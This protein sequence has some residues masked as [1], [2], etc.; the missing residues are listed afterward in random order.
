MAKPDDWRWEMVRHAV[1][2]RKDTHFIACLGPDIGFPGFGRDDEESVDG[3]I[4]CGDYGSSTGL[5]VIPLIFIEH[6]YPWL[7][8][9][10]NEPPLPCA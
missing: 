4:P 7:K 5:L 3:L 9:Y 10:C 6:V 1:R 2:E 8:A